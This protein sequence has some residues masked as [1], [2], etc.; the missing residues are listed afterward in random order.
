VYREVCRLSPVRY[1]RS[2]CP[3]LIKATHFGPSPPRP[4]NDQ[5]LGYSAHSRSHGPM[6]DFHF[7]GVS[8]RVLLQLLILQ[9]GSL[10]DHI[11]DRRRHAEVKTPNITMPFAASI[12]SSVRQCL[13]MAMSP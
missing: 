7:H 9:P 3:E 10:L 5:L 4:I 11:H 8:S 12:G 1:R 2:Q 6:L 13:D